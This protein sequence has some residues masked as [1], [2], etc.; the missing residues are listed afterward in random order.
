ME[1]R[2]RPDA[3][4]IFFAGRPVGPAGSAPVVS[5]APRAKEDAVAMHRKQKLRPD[6]GIRRPSARNFPKVLSLSLS[7]SPSFINDG[8]RQPQI[9]YLSAIPGRHWPVRWRA[10][11]SHLT[12]TGSH[13][14][15]TGH[16]CIIS[17]D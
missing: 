10:W 1:M 8:R 15:A 5:W 6:G 12:S 14:L 2:R 9:A 11:L 4:Y 16:R 3:D 7:R 13:S 17:N